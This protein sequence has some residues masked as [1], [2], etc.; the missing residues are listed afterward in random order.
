MQQEAEERAK[1]LKRAV[2]DVMDEGH[3][4]LAAYRNRGVP[5]Q[6]LR[7]ELRARGWNPKP[8]ARAK[9]LP[10]PRSDNQT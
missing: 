6:A 2:E 5:E 1:R 3:T 9:Q 4:I 8:R 7:D 10:P